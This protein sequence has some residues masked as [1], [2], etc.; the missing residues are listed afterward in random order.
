MHTLIH[1]CPCTRL[2]MERTRDIE[3]HEYVVKG[4]KPLLQI[5]D[6]PHNLLREC[7][8]VKDYVVLPCR[9]SCEVN[10]CYDVQTQLEGE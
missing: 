4:H 1:T 7:T 10:E 2:A 3:S 5:N 9:F 8:N 6:S